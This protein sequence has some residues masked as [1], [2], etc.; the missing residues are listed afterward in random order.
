MAIILNIETSSE[1]CSVALSRNGVSVASLQ[2]SESRSHAVVLTVLINEL[3]QNN[4]LAIRD[5]DAV[6]V[7]KGPGSYTGLRIGVSVAKGLCYGANK[8]LIAINTLECMLFGLKNEYRDFE[9]KFPDDAIFCPMLDARRQEV[10]MSLF[11]K[12]GA[13]I[14]ETSAEIIHEE[15]LKEELRLHPVVL[16]GSGAEKCKTIISNA[17][18]IFIDGFTLKAEYMSLLSEE[19]Y[20]QSKFENLAYFEPFYLKDFIAT[21]PRRK[22]I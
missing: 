2:N 18:A 4:Q 21:I 12:N 15:S 1:N 7:S 16:F 19:A 20:S 17:N 13:V 5:L 10:Y 6:A 11:K 14:S 9:N 22:V 8:P 3:L